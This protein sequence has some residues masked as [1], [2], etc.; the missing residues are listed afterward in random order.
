MASASVIAFAV[1]NVAPG[2]YYQALRLRPEISPA[3]VEAMRSEHGLDQ[4]LP[5]RYLHWVRSVAQGDWGFSLAYSAPARP[6]LWSRA[7]NTLLLGATATLLAWLIAIPL[8]LWA[9]AHPANWADSLTSTTVSI[10]LATPELVLALVML[11][12][13]VRTGYFPAGG[14]MLSDAA[15]NGSAL[16]PFWVRMGDISKHLF[17]P[18]VCLA[19]ALL[20]LLLLHVRTSCKEALRSPF[21]VAARAYGIPFRRVLLHHVLR[22]AANP[23]ISLF[24]LSI[25]LMMSSSLVV[26]AVFSWPGLGQLMLEAILQ[27]DFLVVVDAVMLSTGFLITG[28]LLADVLLYA[29]DP[30]IRAE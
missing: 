7:K 1:V 13:A 15:Q 12:F 22:A 14:L 19:A 11:L 27:R 9:A 25:G 30:R 5:V 8:G 3:T 2:D 29:S 10:L 28:N 26:E 23:L 21:V 24:G 4:S 18:S 17:L 6:I 16:A 20:P